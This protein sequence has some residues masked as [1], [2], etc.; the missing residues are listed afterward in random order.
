MPDITIFVKPTAT[1]ERIELSVDPSILVQDL[2]NEIAKHSPIAAEDQRVIYRGQILKDERTVESYGIANE[3]V[4]H[5][6]RG[7]PAQ[8][9]AAAQAPATA[10][11]AANTPGLGSLPMGMGMLG[12][13]QMMSE[14]MNSPLMQTMLSDPEV[15]RSMFTNNP[16]IREMM[17]RNPELGQMMNNPAMLQQIME[18]ARNP[19]LMQE[20]MRQADRQLHN[21]EAMPEGFNRLRQMYE[22]VQEPMLNAAM[23][24]NPSNMTSTN[25]L[26]ALLGGGAGAAA[27]GT[28][29]GTNPTSTSGT[30]GAAAATPN[31]DPLPNPWAPGQGAA[32]GPGAPGAAAGGVPVGLGGLGLGGLMGRG[33]GGAGLASP[34]A[35]AQMMQNPMV[36]EAVRSMMSNPALMQSMMDTN[37]MMRSMLQGNPM[38]RSAVTSL[39][40]NPQLMEQM[41]NPANLQAM[42]QMQTAMQQL[43]NS[44]LMPNGMPAPDASAG[45]GGFGSDEMRAMMSQIMGADAR[46]AVVTDPETTYA[47]QLQQLQD[48]GFYDRQAN[49][50]ALQATGGNV[51]AAVERLL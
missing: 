11:A 2:K 15:L 27:R 45:L 3:H 39:M 17:D 12:D 19:S 34:E 29:A 25:P 24:S 38:M 9:S 26:L 8:P 43:Q 51:N 47:S 1:G 14:M 36:N 32:A 48:M 18:V 28:A 33:M 23:S 50:A 13:P 41:L 31:A 4:L 6:V 22:N 40:S 16:A 30:D 35:M 46:P 21:I 20:Q 7:R 5:L 49:I 42:A 10:A 44:G 37:P